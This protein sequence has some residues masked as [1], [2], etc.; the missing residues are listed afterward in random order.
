[1]SASTQTTS[2]PTRGASVPTHAAFVAGY[3]AGSLQVVVDR[4]AAA[5]FVAARAM[6]PFVLLPVFGVAVGF[7]LTGHWIAGALAF[8]AGLGLRALVRGSAQGYVL[9]RALRE[10]A[11]YE[12]AVA[13]GLVV[14]TTTGETPDTQGR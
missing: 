7:A 8:L 14:M 10:A 3:H 13:A 6:L 12:Q 5:R 11:F 4:A 1:M 2:A 9:T